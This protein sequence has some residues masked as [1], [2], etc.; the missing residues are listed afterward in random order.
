[1]WVCVLMCAKRASL[2]EKIL[3]SV[4]PSPAPEQQDRESGKLLQKAVV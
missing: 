2:K 3:Y 1:M 4:D